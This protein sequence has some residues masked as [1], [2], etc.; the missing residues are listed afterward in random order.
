MFKLREVHEIIFISLTFAL[1]YIV[2]FVAFVYFSAQDNQNLKIDSNSLVVI[3]TGGGDRIKEGIKLANEYDAYI[4][5]SGVYSKSSVRD[6]LEIN[7]ID[8]EPQPEKL[9]VGHFAQNTKEN[10]IEADICVSNNGLN[11][12][13]LVTSNYHG[14]RSK[15]WFD[16][17]V[18][19]VPVVVMPVYGL[20]LSWTSILT[21][22]SV[23]KLIFTEYNKYLYVWVEI[24][25]NKYWNFVKMR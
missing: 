21:E 24:L 2:G 18:K 22:Y 12:I 13:V 19:D 6:I 11:R 7:G 25:Y 17:Y 5:I 20:D 3:V 23:F 16:F 15:A 1:I 4:L 10:A 9:F 8:K 14:L